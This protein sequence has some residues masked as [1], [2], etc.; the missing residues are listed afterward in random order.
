MSLF[1]KKKKANPAGRVTFMEK[2]GGCV[3]TKSLLGGKTRLKW[4]FRE[5][6]VNPVDNGW[7]FLGESDTGQYI[8][9]PGNNAVVDFNTV[10]NMEPAV[11]GIYQMP[12]GTDLRFEVAKDGSRHF[13]DNHTGTEVIIQYG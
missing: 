10:A 3:C 11:L 6:S 12:V 2:A 9:T 5:Q 1:G 7:R 8:N 13:Y 4:C